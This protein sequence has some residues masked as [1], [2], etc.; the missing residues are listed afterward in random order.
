MKRALILLFVAGCGGDNNNPGSIDMASDE[1]DLARPSPE[2]LGP[3][4][5][6][7]RPRNPSVAAWVRRMPAAA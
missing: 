3:A 5:N 2:P 4:I 7:P 6:T 1:V